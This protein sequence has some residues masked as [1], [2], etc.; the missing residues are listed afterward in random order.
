MRLFTFD[1]GYKANLSR[2]ELQVE[3]LE[4]EGQ[5][6][7]INSEVSTLNGVNNIHVNYQTGLARVEYNSE[8]VTPKEII[9]VIKKLSY[10][11]H[12]TLTASDKQEMERQKE[13]HDY[14][15]RFFLSL[16]FALPV[17]GY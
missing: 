9:N 3:G 14:K 16:A 6:N 17:I 1:I 4:N 10:S 7:Q 12:E 2:L 8:E 13:I 15:R 11:A 5:A